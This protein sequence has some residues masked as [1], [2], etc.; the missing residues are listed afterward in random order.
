MPHFDYYSLVWDCLI[1][2]FSDKLQKLKQ[3]EFL[4]N[5]P[6]IQAQI[7]SSPPQLEE[8]ISWTKETNSLND[9]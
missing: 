2:Y 3:P 6:L 1:G 5:P 7:T 8:A 4:L 9:V